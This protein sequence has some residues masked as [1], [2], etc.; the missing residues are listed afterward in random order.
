MDLHEY[1]EGQGSKQSIATCA[2]Q[3]I[4]TLQLLHNSPGGVEGYITAFEQALQDLAEC[5]IPYHAT[6]KK[7]SFLRGIMDASLEN[8]T[9]YLEMDDTKSYDDCV[10]EL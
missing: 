2:L 1:Y 10:Q 3:C 4:L 6:M 9:M 8:I 5:N 7:V